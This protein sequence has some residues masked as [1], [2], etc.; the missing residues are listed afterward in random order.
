M[1]FPGPSKGVTLARIRR[2]V[3][4]QFR[5]PSP[6]ARPRPTSRSNN[7]TLYTAS[8]H[9]DL[10]TDP[11]GS[12]AS[13]L[14][15]NLIQDSS[16]AEQFR[17]RQKVAQDDPLGQSITTSSHLCLSILAREELLS[18]SHPIDHQ[19]GARSQ[20]AM[21]VQSYHDDLGSLQSYEGNH[22]RAVRKSSRHLY[23]GSLR[24]RSSG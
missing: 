5:R 11:L 21:H 10:P 14:S 8:S 18:K 16:G 15:Q 3:R 1:S 20:Y 6:F 9:H 19:D 2:A 4:R 22:H 23:I 17:Q 12:T 7:P 13:F 24:S